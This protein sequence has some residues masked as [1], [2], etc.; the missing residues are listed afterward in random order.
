[1][2]E[3]RYPYRPLC[4]C[5]AALDREEKSVTGISVVLSF[6]CPELS[7][8]VLRIVSLLPVQIRTLYQPWFPSGTLLSHLRRGGGHLLAAVPLCR[9]PAPAVSCLS[10]V[11]QRAG[12]CDRLVHGTH[13]SRE[14]VGLFLCAAEPA[15]TC[16]LSGRGP[17]WPVERT[18]LQGDRA[19]IALTVGPP[20]GL[21]GRWD[22]RVVLCAACYG[23]DCRSAQL[24]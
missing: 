8:M 7:R 20:A 3:V 13:V 24:E 11:L 9:I 10:I 22:L 1:M 6:F 12:V 18:C 16:L 19:G 2:R 5:G 17:V 23:S 14:V 15:R 4:R 21:G